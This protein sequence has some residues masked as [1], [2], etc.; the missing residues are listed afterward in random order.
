[1]S[2]FAGGDCAARAEAA[3][4]DDG[5]DRNDRTM[6]AVVVSIGASLVVGGLAATVNHALLWQQSDIWTPT[7]FSVLWYG[8]GGVEPDSLEWLGIGGI[9]A[10]LLDQ[11][12]NVVLFVVGGT[13]VWI[14]LAFG[15]RS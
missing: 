13:M 15:R 14:G 2:T 8:L 11:P 12:L 10:W 7:Q 4:G 5:A 9:M 6:R 3:P 1:L